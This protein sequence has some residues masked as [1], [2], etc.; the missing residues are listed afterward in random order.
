MQ[1]LQGESMT[2]TVNYSDNVGVG[3]DWCDELRLTP[4][5]SAKLCSD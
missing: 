2:D 4:T 5:T 1:S 3:T